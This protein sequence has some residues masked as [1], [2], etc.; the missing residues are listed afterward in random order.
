MAKR[1]AVETT[2]ADRLREFRDNLKIDKHDLDT[3]LIEQAGLYHSVSDESALAMSRRDKAKG[4][5]EETYSQ[6]YLDIRRKN[7]KD[8]PS[9]TTLKHMVEVDETYLEAQTEYLRLKK[10]AD[11]W[12]ALVTAFHDRSYMLR[13]L[14]TLYVSG[15]FMDSSAG[16]T[17]NRSGA[18]GRVAEDNKTA[19]GKKRPDRE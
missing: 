10:L 3:M 14:A 18:S 12:G 1:I 6:T 17:A 9:E 19:A 11:R 4:V 16:S 7:A 15:Y 8:K 2:E 5:M 13:E